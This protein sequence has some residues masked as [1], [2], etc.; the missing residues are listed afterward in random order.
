[1]AAQAQRA[2]SGAAMQQRQNAVNAAMM[3]GRGRP[4]T[5]TKTSPVG[6]VLRGQHH[7]P[8][9]RPPPLPSNMNMPTNFQIGSSGQ[10]IQ[11]CGGRS[12]RKSHF[13]TT[14]FPYSSFTRPHIGRGF[15]FF[16]FW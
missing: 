2:A 6:T 16:F 11:V 14:T 10:F 5:V 13:T 8:P 12:Q 9:A 15:F 7:T 4:Q 3:R 1:M